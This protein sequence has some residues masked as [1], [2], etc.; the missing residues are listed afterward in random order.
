MLALQASVL[1]GDYRFSVSNMDKN[2][3]GIND[4]LT[5]RVAGEKQVLFTNIILYRLFRV[6]FLAVYFFQKPLMEHPV[7]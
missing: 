2:W 3:E 5:L 1:S 6:P 4:F 7:I